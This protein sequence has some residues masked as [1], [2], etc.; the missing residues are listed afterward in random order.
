M[1]QQ[2]SG[3]G[4][5]ATLHYATPFTHLAPKATVT[6]TF[7]Y[8]CDN[9]YTTTKE[10]DLV[11]PTAS[12]ASNAESV[13]FVLAENAQLTIPTGSCLNIGNDGASC[14]VIARS[15]HCRIIVDGTLSCDGN[16]TFRAEEGA[17]LEIVFNNGA[18]LAMSGVTFEN[19]QLTLPQRNVTFDSCTFKG[20]PVQLVMSSSQRSNGEKA[21]VRNCTFMPNNKQI[22]TALFIKN[23]PQFLV[24]NCSFGTDEGA[25]GNGIYIH[26]GG[27]NSGTAQVINNDI[28]GC[29]HAG[30]QLYG[31][32][33]GVFGNRI[34]GNEV[35]VKLLNNSNISSFSGNCGATDVE[36]TQYI[37]DNTSH[38]VYMTGSS[39]PQTFR[40]NAICDDDNTPF[41]FHEAYVSQHDPSTPQ[42]R[43]ESI[44][45]TY[46]HWG[47]NFNPGVHLRTDIPDGY[48]HTPTWA[49][50]ECLSQHD[51]AARQ[52]AVADSLNE[53]GDY[54]EASLAYRG[55]VRDYPNSISAETALKTLLTLEEDSN[56][57]YSQ[58]KD[59][60]KGSIDIAS[61]SV[62]SS[63][64]DKLA[65]KCD[66]AQRN[67]QDAIVWYEDVIGNPETSY[68]DSIFA[69]IDLGDL[70]LEM[71]ENGEKALG[72]MK[73]FKPESEERHRTLT[74][75][76]LASLPFCKLDGGNGNPVEELHA[77]ITE[78]D[79]VLIWNYPMESTLDREAMLTWSNGDS[80]TEMAYSGERDCVA[81]RYDSL[82]LMHFDG[83]R[84]KQIS[85]IPIVPENTYTVGVWV[86]N[87][88]RY[89]LAYSHD[90]QNM[91]CGEW[92]QVDLEEDIII[93]RN[94]EYLIGYSSVGDGYYT[95]AGDLK[96]TVPN[97]NMIMQGEEWDISPMSL[98]NWMIRATIASPQEGPSGSETTSLTGYNIY[99]NGELE[100]NI[101][102]AFQ[103][104][105]I[106]KSYNGE[107]P[108]EYCVTAIYEGDESEAECVSVSPLG[109]LDNNG[110]DMPTISPNPTSGIV[111]VGGGMA[112]EIQV[113]N[114]FGQLV[115]RLSNTNEINLSALPHGV[116]TLRIR[117]HSAWSVSRIVLQ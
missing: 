17:S 57:D 6:F 107:F 19:C 91:V 21:A 100:S 25:F 51:D 109:I 53:A 90:V 29:S 59:Y 113:Y 43:G 89:E 98:H 13:G 46:N 99:R 71:E 78:N 36:H 111:R 14:Q 9:H 75:K 103:S 31:T 40:Y 81:H 1:F 35:G 32:T 102:Y 42:V 15:G 12:T 47:P 30:L 27:S 55:V 114:G 7:G 85:M 108:A 67:Y 72:K 93:D 10:I 104:Y 73:Q 77:E 79:I 44:D 82:D 5:A 88:N 76:A 4:Y 34:H 92:N 16:V 33:G 26:G 80:Y 94:K 62:L 45:V 69:V 64:A 50:G 52:L 8:G 97:K 11:I 24:S 41:V 49:M 110:A 38:E 37:H 48:S 115:M 70:Y 54:S 105:Y 83:W 68:C 84:I 63:L 56:E 112:D 2:P 61:D 60:Y 116:Y 28:T 39:I 3:S 96:K 65:N 106:D 101:P 23:Y 74:E 20:T 87:G 58:L 86:K 66:V 22:Q 117:S 95:L 18:D